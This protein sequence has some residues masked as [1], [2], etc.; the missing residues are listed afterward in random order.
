MKRTGRW[1]SIGVLA[2][3]VGAVLGCASG[4]SSTTNDNGC[5]PGRVGPTYLPDNKVIECNCVDG[6]VGILTCSKGAA[7]CFC[8]SDA[9]V[10]SAG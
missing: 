1:G 8:P 4:T 9:G 7:F 2:A 6:G 5:A 10:D 3:F